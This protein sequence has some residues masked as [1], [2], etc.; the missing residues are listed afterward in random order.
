MD[1]ESKPVGLFALLRRLGR[2]AIGTLQNRVELAAVELHE[3]RQRVFEIVML[4][5]AALMLAG[6]ALLLFSAAIVLLFPH[7]Y[8]IYAAFG[9]G[10]LYLAGVAALWF[11]IKARL[12][13][14][15]FSETVNQ[16]RKDVEWLSPP[17]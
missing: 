9:L 14:E 13:S 2:T 10:V 15:P 8:R 4:A 7:G 1:P 16:I 12:V 6:I 17:K 3:E 11:Q 5:G